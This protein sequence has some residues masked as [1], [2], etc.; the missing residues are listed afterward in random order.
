[1]RVRLN[2]GEYPPFVGHRHL[3]E[4]KEKIFPL[5][6]EYVA[7]Q[8]SDINRFKEKIKNLNP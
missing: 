6:K 7:K 3:K 2:G 5:W 8:E 1:M 4:L